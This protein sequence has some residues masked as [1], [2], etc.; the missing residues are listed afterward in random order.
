ME[1]YVPPSNYL[2]E[3]T[4]EVYAQA[5]YYI[6]NGGVGA[7]GWPIQNGDNAVALGPTLYGNGELCGKVGN[8]LAG[9]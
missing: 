8:T 3:D 1:L 7:C 9:M 6:P 2:N 4:D 5:T